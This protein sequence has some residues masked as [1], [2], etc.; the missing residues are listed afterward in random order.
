MTAEIKGPS[1]VVKNAPSGQESAPVSSAADAVVGATSPNVVVARATNGAANGFWRWLRQFFWMGERMELAAR[2]SYAPG[3]PGWEDYQF[4]CSAQTG[5]RQLGESEEGGGAE[6]LLDCAAARL[7][8]R[9][10]LARAGSEL[11][12]T[13]TGDEYWEALAKLPPAGPLLAAISEEQRK[14]AISAL[15]AEGESFLTKLPLAK[16]K[17][18]ACAVANLAMGLRDPLDRDVTLVGVVR[19]V[20]WIRISVALA[21]VLGGLTMAIDKVFSRTNLAL[22]RPVTVVTPHSEYGRDP[23]LLVDGD[24]SNLGFHTIEGPNQNVTIDLGKVR[25]IFRVVVYNRTDCC[26]QRAVPLKIEVSEDNRKFRQVALRKEQ[27]EK[28]KADFPSTDAR[29]VRLTDLSAAAF[30]LSEVEVY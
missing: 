11:G 18:V 5:A 14:L 7:M 20:R 4:G 28:W 17:L 9:A 10:H 2:R 24:L 6:L 16:R 30:H 22:H 21:L 1:D 27:F 29:Y 8:I 3:Q 26:Q 13:A 15:G 23:S 25:H 12:H 19:L